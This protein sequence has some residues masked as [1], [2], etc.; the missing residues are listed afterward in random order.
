MAEKTST[1]NEERHEAACRSEEE[2]RSES[3]PQQRRCAAT[4]GCGPAERYS[5]RI[6]SGDAVWP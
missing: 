5:E 2:E 4:D 1:R 3:S 6:A